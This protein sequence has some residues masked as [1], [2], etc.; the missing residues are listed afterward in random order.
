MVSYCV[1][2]HGAVSA[3]EKNVNSDWSIGK[4]FRAK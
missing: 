4:D 3:I 1:F 2:S